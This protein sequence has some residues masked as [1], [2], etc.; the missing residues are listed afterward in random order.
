MDKYKIQKEVFGEQLMKN[1]NPT[2]CPYTPALPATTNF[3]QQTIARFPC[4]SSCVHF[5]RDGNQVTI[6]CGSKDLI[7]S[8]DEE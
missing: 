8:L 2:I 4:M 6:S 5:N 1:G 3:G 7:I